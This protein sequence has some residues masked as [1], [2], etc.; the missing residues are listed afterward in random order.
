MLRE[1]EPTEEQVREL[2]PQFQYVHFAT[3]GFFAPPELI[4][5]L[6]IESHADQDA[7]ARA[8]KQGVAGF[9][10]G[11]LSGIVL[12][13][14][15]Q[16]VTSNRDDGILTALEISELDFSQVDL[17]ALSACE[18]GLGQSASSEGLLGLQRAFQIAGARSVVASLWKLRDDA[19]R[20]LMVDFYDNLWTK[21]LSKAES[22][23]RAQ[24]TMMREGIKRGLV[25]LDDTSAAKVPEVPP[26][27]W[28]AFVLS[29]DWR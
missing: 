15:N 12:A 18:T 16:P 28:A 8:I 5:S 6:S 23:R 19:A 14:A 4:S 17:A 22:L 26:Y 3:H 21:K 10:P 7:N 24:L 29:G 1:S 25:V 2:A 13:G 20:Q 11:L 27:F 9:H